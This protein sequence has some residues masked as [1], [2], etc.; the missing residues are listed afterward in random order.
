MTYKEAYHTD[1]SS[2]IQSYMY[3]IICEIIHTQYTSLI[4]LPLVSSHGRL[5]LLA[6]R[7]DAAVE[8]V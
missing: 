3:T 4:L 2:C 7:E 8:P 1:L 5:R 6:Q